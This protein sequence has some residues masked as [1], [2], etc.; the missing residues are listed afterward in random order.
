[1]SGIQPKPYSLYP[2]IDES[3]DDEERTAT[4]TAGE[5]FRRRVS[6]P[7][8]TT[9]ERESTETNVDNDIVLEVQDSQTITQEKCRCGNCGEMPSAVER[10]CCMQESHAKTCFQQADVESGYNPKRDCILCSNLLVFHLLGTVNLQLAWFRHRRLQ[11]Y[12]GNDL[13]FQH[14]DNTNYRYYAYRS[15]IDFIHGYLG[16]RRRKVIPACV[17]THIRSKWPDENGQYTGFKNL[18][19]DS[20][21]DQDELARL[22]TD[23]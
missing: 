17:V 9:V 19:E 5:L 14:M 3:D 21:E 12:T 6:V 23:E 15:Y 7:A 2:L 22:L 13:L 11:G 16:P 8:E 10:K 20:E 4:I 1:M 18:D